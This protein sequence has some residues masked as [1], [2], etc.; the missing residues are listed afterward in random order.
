MNNDELFERLK[1]V[2]KEEVTASE[3]RVKSDLRQEIQAS[4]ER[5]TQKIA[6][7]QEETIDVLSAVIHT[8]YNMHEQRISAIEEQLDIPH[9]N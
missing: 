2:I 1:N 6:A 3:N 8:G 4:E 5:L 7:S 9:K